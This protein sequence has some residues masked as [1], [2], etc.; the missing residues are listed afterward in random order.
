MMGERLRALCAEFHR[1]ESGDG[2]LSKGD[3]R[4]VSRCR[5]WIHRQLESVAREGDTGIIFPGG[6]GERVASDRKGTGR[7]HHEFAF[8]RRFAALLENANPDVVAS[9]QRQERIDCVRFD[10]L[11]ARLREDGLHV[12]VQER[13]G[14]QRCHLYV[15]WAQT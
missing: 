11:V 3:N 9:L 15:S 1:G 7:S 14:G 5:A 2:S 6:A 4:W 8:P 13:Q 12:D 10:A